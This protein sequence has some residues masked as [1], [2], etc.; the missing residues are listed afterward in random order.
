MITGDTKQKIL[1]LFLGLFTA[2]LI[3]EALFRLRKGELTHFENQ[4]VRKVNE[5]P[6][7]CLSKSD[8]KLG[9]KTVSNQ[10]AWVPGKR[11]SELK[12][13]V[14]TQ[15]FGIRNNGFE[16]KFQKSGFLALGDSLTFG[17]EV[18][19][20]ETWP[21][22]LQQK[23]DIPVFNAGAC[24]YGVDQA[25]FRFLDLEPH[26]A[27]RGVLLSITPVGVARTERKFMLTP[28]FKKTNK[29]YKTTEPQKQTK[30]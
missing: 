5:R 30:R 19:D 27:L 24:S 26:L 10:S 15:D 11:N 16:T 18:S 8:S 13:F 3:I 1:A 23:L 6:N 7:P 2:F 21:S 20:A 14:S 22:Y 9:W 29:N 17:D 4:I 28:F 12:T 25:Y